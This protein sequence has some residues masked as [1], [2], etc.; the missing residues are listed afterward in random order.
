MRSLKSVLVLCLVAAASVLVAGPAAAREPAP[1]IEISPGSFA[2]GPINVGGEL[3]EPGEFTVTN[4]GTA[5]AHLIEAGV[6][7][8]DSFSFPFLAN[9]STCFFLEVPGELA[10]GDSCTLVAI[11]DPV[12]EGLNEAELDLVSDATSSPDVMPLT[13]TGLPALLPG[14]GMAPQSGEFG[15]QLLGSG[16]KPKAFTLTSTGTGDL[17]V[18]QATLSG[19]DADQFSITANGCSGRVIASGDGC[20]VEV[21]FIPTGEGAKSAALTVETNADG[22]DTTVALTGTGTDLPPNAGTSRIRLGRTLPRLGRVAA[23]ALPLTC[24]VDGMDACQGRIAIRARGRALGLRHNRQVVVGSRAYRAEPGRTT[25][26]V[27]LGA[28][29]RRAVR[30]GSLRLRVLAT[31]R[32]GNGD[33]SQT[34]ATRRLRR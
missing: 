21:T 13:G 7:G 2:F 10:P 6:S 28:R 34:A 33:V 32:Q 30:R 19:P 18:G 27:R 24:S 22:A 5:P 14:A 1:T 20:A 16:S 31:T 15:E 26:R 25:I 4:T 8:L 29:A 3:G 9:A 23:V 12:K 17:N 11:F